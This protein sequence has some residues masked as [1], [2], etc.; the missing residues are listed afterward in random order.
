MA[1]V[2]VEREQFLRDFERLGVSGVVRERIRNWAPTVSRY[3]IPSQKLVYRSP[4]RRY[5]AW[6]ARI[7]NPDS[8][9][10]K[11]GGYR[12]I[13][14]L[15]LSECTINLDYIEERDNI[16][17]GKEGTRRKQKYNGYVTAVKA[18]LARRDPATSF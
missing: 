12:V 1:W 15:D 4:G 13:F 18:E 5:E 3:E 10:G 16:G 9:K 2:L 8:N 11:R 6:S 14:F 17:F 7:P